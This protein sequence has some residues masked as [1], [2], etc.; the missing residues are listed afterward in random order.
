MFAEMLEL[1][2]LVAQNVRIWGP[3][4][5]ILIQQITGCE[6]RDTFTT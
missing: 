1:D 6:M 5:L 4:L 3:T 2:V